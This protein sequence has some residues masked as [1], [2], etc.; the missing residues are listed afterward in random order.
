MSRADN[1]AKHRLGI[2]REALKQ[3]ENYVPDWRESDSDVRFWLK[4]LA[5][6]A[7]KDMENLK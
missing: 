4:D 6:Q 5:H 7:L 1:I 2:A 3:I